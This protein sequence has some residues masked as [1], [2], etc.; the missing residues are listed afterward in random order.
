MPSSCRVDPKAGTPSENRIEEEEPCETPWNRTPIP[1]EE[2]VERSYHEQRGQALTSWTPGPRPAWVDRLNSLGENLGDDGRSLMPLDPEEMLHQASLVTGLQEY[3]DGFFRE[4]LRVFAESLE[5]EAELT[6]LGRILARSEIQ[7][8][9]QNRLRIEDHLERNPEILTESVE[10]PIFVTGLGRSG[11]TFLH[12]LLA[13]DPT[14]RVPLLWEMMYS[15]PP[16]DSKHHQSDPRA[17]AAHR[18]ITLMD[19][20]DPAFTAM[21]ENAGDLPSE[22]IFIFAHQFATD[23]WVGTY[24]VPSYTAWLSSSDI[25]PAYDYHRR[26][27]QL[28]QSSHRR[29][30]WVLKA[31]SH[32]SSLP[33]LF[34]T[35]PDARVV[36]THRDP[37]KVIAS[38]A[39][40]MATLQWMRSRKVHYEGI[41]SAMAFGLGFLLER[42]AAERDSGLVP[43]EQISDIRYADL[44][45]N[46]LNTLRR[47]YEDWG[48]DL[49]DEM[50]RRIRSYLENRHQGRVALHDYAFEDTGLSLESER[51]RHAP[52]QERFGVA[53]EI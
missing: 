52:Y 22:C 18:E 19:A 51:A 6:L 37:L 20:I 16:P 5:A 21:H 44:V 13:L 9:L 38:L 32:L 12:E 26:F 42:S 34:Q 24:P 43:E 45:A 3:G 28:L 39:N 25:Q 23:M 35:Y 17:A 1:L 53:S 29:E 7:R 4:P 30:R 49:S 46:P 48:L 47:L 50:E 11:T 40:L 15:S 2:I 41:V 33:H 31:P 36:I 10:A 8:I 27:L 14:N